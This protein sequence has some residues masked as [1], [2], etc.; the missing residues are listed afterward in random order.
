MDDRQQGTPWSDVNFYSVSMII[1]LQ[2]DSFVVA[3]LGRISKREIAEGFR[4]ILGL[5]LP[6]NHELYKD[7]PQGT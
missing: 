1:R 7:M 6:H 3:I 4:S 5:S 2:F